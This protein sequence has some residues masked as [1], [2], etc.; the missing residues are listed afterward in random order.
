MTTDGVVKAAGFRRKNEENCWNVDSWNALRRRPWDVTER[1]TEAAEAIQ[2]PR[3]LFIHLPL[4][5]R[6]RHITRA[7]LRKYGVAIGCSAC[8]DI[9]VHAKTTKPHMSNK[10]W[11]ANGARF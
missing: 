2:A 10:D 6:G 4:A 9:A 5:P 3:P 11:R 8:S 1:R 7:D